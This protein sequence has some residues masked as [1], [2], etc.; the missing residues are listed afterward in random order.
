MNSGTF[1]VIHA[2]SN[3]FMPMGKAAA[4][5]ADMLARHPDL[6]VL[7]EIGDAATFSA[8]ANESGAGYHAL[9]PDAGDIAFLVSKEARILGSGG[10]LAIPAQGG[11][12]RLGGHGPRHNSFVT[13]RLRNEFISHTGVHFV[14]AHPDHEHNTGDRRDEQIK[15]ANLMGQQVQKFGHGRNLSTGSGDLNAELPHLADMQA[16]FDKWRLTTTAEEEQDFDPTHGS[17]RLDYV[18]SYDRDTRLSV[19]KMDVLHGENSDHR[20]VEVFFDIKP[21]RTR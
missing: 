2:S 9:N 14:T 11:P 3:T 12:A 5:T 20:P 21:L 1:H 8:I 18:W 6:L 17:A 15:Q 7:T 4:D 19:R 16:V 10:P 13:F